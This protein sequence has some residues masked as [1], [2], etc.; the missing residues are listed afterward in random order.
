MPGNEV[1]DRVHN[2]FDQGSLSQDQHHTQV[3]SNWPLFNNNIWSGSEAV[4]SGSENYSAQQSDVE[5]GQGHQFS[6]GPHGLNFTRPG[7]RPESVKGSS[8]IQQLNMNGY[9]HPSQV[10]HPRQN[11]ANF[12]GVNTE[13]DRHNMMTRNPSVLESHQRSGSH[14]SNSGSFGGSESPMNFNFLGGQQH[15]NGQQT[16]ILQSLSR[17]QPGNNDTQLQQQLMLK[18][19]QELQRHHQ[20]QQSEAIQ[21]SATNHISPFINQAAGQHQSAVN[22]NPMRDTSNYAWPPPVMPG[23]SNWQQRGMSS[24]VPGY[25][26]GF[27]VTPDHSQGMQF[28]GMVPQ[29]T[30][31]SLYGVPVSG[32]RSSNAFYQNNTDKSGMLQVPTPSTF[33]GNQYGSLAEQMNVKDGNMVSRYGSDGKIS[34]EQASSQHMGHEVNSGGL[35]QVQQRNMPMSERGGQG[36]SGVSDMLTEKSVNQ[37]SSQTIG[38]DPTEEKILFGNDDNTSIWDAFGEESLAGSGDATD[39]LNGFSSVQSGTWSALMQSA[40]GETSS[41]DVGMQEEWNGLG[42]QNSRSQSGSQHPSFTHANEKSRRNLVDSSQRGSLGSQPGTS[43]VSTYN[44]NTNP[45]YVNSSGQ[46]QPFPNQ[47][48]EYLQT[49]S[50]NAHEGRRW[51]EISQQ[52]SHAEQK[53]VVENSNTS[54]DCSRADVGFWSHQQN[55]FL[56]NNV[57]QSSRPNA[58]NFIGSAPENGGISS[59]YQNNLLEKDH[60]MQ[61]Y[62]DTGPGSASRLDP[63]PNS[64]IK[65]DGGFVNP[66]D[67]TGAP[68]LSN[69]KVNLESGQKLPNSY[70][71]DFW[72]PVNS[73]KSGLEG[74]VRDR[75]NLSKGPPILESSDNSPDGGAVEMHESE[76]SDRRESSSDSHRSSF[77]HNASV[78]VSRENMWSNSAD[79]RS[80]SGGKEKPSDQ[81]GKRGLVARKFQYHPMGD[82]DMDLDSSHPEKQ[83]LLSQSMAQ[84]SAGIRG[85]ELNPRFHGSLNTNITDMEK[86]RTSNFQGPGNA[87]RGVSSGGFH[88][89]FLPNISSQFL[90]SSEI[91]SSNQQIPTSQNMLELLHKVDQSKEQS[92][93]SDIPSQGQFPTSHGFSLQLAPPSQAIASSNLNDAFQNSS[94]TVDSP[95]SGHVASEMG[96]KTHTWLASV[97]SAHCLPS[98]LQPT[99]L[100]S[101]NESGG[102][103]NKDADVVVP[104]FKENRSARLSS[105]SSLSS[106]LTNQ[107]LTTPGGKLPS[108]QSA[109]VS[110]NRHAYHDQQLSGM[111]PQAITNHTAGNSHNLLSGRDINQPGMSALMRQMPASL[112]AVMAGMPRKD[113]LSPL[114]SNLWTSQQQL[115]GSPAFKAP[116]M[117]KSQFHSPDASETSFTQQKKDEQDVPI[118]VDSSSSLGTGVRESQTAE[119]P[120]VKKSG[121]SLEEPSVRRLQDVSPNNNAHNSYSLLHQMQNMRNIGSDPSHR[122][123]KRLKGHDDGLDPQLGDQNTSFQLPHESVPSQDSPSFG[124][125][126]PQKSVTANVTCRSENTGISPQMAPSWFERYGTFKNGQLLPGHNVPRIPMLKNVEQQ[127]TA[128]MT[129]GSQ[130]VNTCEAA[131]SHI[132]S[133]HVSS[134]HASVTHVC[135]SSLLSARTKKRKTATSDLLPW[136]KEIGQSLKR[137]QNMS[138]AEV[139]WAHSSNRLIEKVEDDTDNNEDLL[140]TIRPKR[141]LLLT[142]QLMQQVFQP[143]SA[144]VLSLDASSDY[145]YIVYSLARSVL[146]DACNL[147]CGVD[148]NSAVENGNPLCGKVKSSE[149]IQD[150]YFS[151]A[152]EDFVTREKELE[153]NLLRLDKRAS[154]LDFRL[155]CQDLERFSVINRFARFHGRG[156]AD[157][158]EKSS[159]SDATATVLKPIPQRYVSAH[160]MPRNVPERVQCL[161]L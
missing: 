91:S 150:Q 3:A 88:P 103:G 144:T 138:S 45:N 141:R 72:K 25:S 137:L 66:K 127:F 28:L 78:G 31:Q 48:K 43:N 118:R 51:L 80:F 156:Q 68:G 49:E 5:R 130:I 65:M 107:H 44:A 157:G 21:R 55:T 27:M 90:R 84:L 116:E 125:N 61:I 142:T 101:G 135:A 36:F 11:E 64:T 29:Q 146:G 63:V 131:K 123:S 155:E 69:M 102:L 53:G 85:Q 81:T 57:Q 42:S 139:D 76:N 134:L 1:G 114:G 75:H 93:L 33:S 99:P 129:E 47:K 37:C 30:S 124:R 40:V 6:L 95:S 154:I 126:D 161:S 73:G 50:M 92:L 22:G 74:S 4:N 38:L 132:P 9:M 148:S 82:V 119:A 97:S 143:P 15:M 12:L 10:G 152:V 16:E 62:M 105:S 117:I 89:G 110:F 96:D 128:A 35:T 94:R 18:Q 160:S 109:T 112:H 159:S 87:S 67:D 98:P 151:K 115:L 70:H 41:T 14:Q 83:V 79:R 121:V 8:Q 39:L 71:L 108:D 113:N 86:G 46:Q 133:E 147:V 145:E 153:N 136:N 77:P 34:F 23:N 111:Q 120:S 58:S 2:F 13:P 60:N 59:S 32:S 7:S 106:P 149:R 122:E 140:P 104:N 24:S 54:R 52:K 56:H 26:N 19:M 100:E 17:Q 158:T 20:L